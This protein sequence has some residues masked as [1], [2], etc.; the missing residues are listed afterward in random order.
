[1]RRL[2]LTIAL[3]TSACAPAIVPPPVVTTPKFPDFV[4]PVVP[5]AVANGAAAINQ[6]RGW[7]FLQNG[8]FKPAEYEFA[9]ALQN[10]PSF[11]P[12][13]TSL[14]YLALARRDAKGALP[15]FD[16]VLAEHADD[17]AALN[18]KGQALLA[19]NREDEALAVFE[20]ALAADPNQ[21]EV[22]R[23]VDV[24]KFRVSEQEI[25]HARQAA[26]AG[27][28]DEAA[29]A[30]TAAIAGSPDS[31]F[32]YRELAG[33][34]RQQG[35][36][37]AAVEYFRKALALDATDA[38]SLV[39]IGEIQETRGDLEAA[40]QSYSE[41]AAL[42]PGDEIARKL[43]GV[44]T[45]SALA[46]LPAEYRAIDQA[47]QITRA[48]LAALVGIRLGR[49]LQGTERSEA[50][51]ITDVRNHWAQTWIM[52]VARA[53]VMEPFANHQFQ[54]RTLVRRAD[55]AQAAAR[56]LARIGVERPNLAREW[57][58][59]RLRFSD[60]APTHLAYP[61]ASAAVAAGVMKTAAD[62]SFQ[63]ARPVTGAEAVEA[64]AHLESLA[65]PGRKE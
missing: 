6:S 15:H 34:L 12:A 49:L 62:N 32:L 13:E 7:A 24:L 37:D 63:P 18:G 30:Y 55:L 4:R 38:R 17:N 65:G 21:P 16:R 59:S 1:M 33:V 9:A 48:D 60:L 47:Q 14:G 8:D 29:Q 43:E 44:R 19:L 61:A 53:G 57:E 50:A 36:P 10:D 58:S 28:L 31:P 64:V 56:L 2:L 41:A 52:A 25:A 5:E 40:E 35:K 39:Q 20:R 27:H 54:P 22:T 51:L 11:F 26:R 46:K 3:C 23:R 42:E 45:K